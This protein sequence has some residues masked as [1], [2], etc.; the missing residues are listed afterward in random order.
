M[1]TKFDQ[2]Y[3]Y[4]S[5]VYGSTSATDAVDVTSNTRN[6]GICKSISD[7]VMQ[8]LS[9]FGNVICAKLVKMIYE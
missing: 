2:L 5:L 1:Q 9:F 8:E 6:A 4:T 3:W 7:T